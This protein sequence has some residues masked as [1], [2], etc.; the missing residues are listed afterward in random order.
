MSLPVSTLFARAIGRP[1]TSNEGQALFEA[2]SISEA[3][4]QKH[5][6]GLEELRWSINTDQGIQL[7]FENSGNMADIASHDIGKRHWLLTEALFWNDSTLTQSHGTV[8]PFG[9]RFNM[10]R[11]SV[12]KCLPVSKRFTAATADVW[13]GDSFELVVN[14]I[15]D[16]QVIRYVSYG[17]PLEIQ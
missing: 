12:Q 7:E 3:D 2:L 5:P 9:I 8:M 16:T 17:M 15:E 6:M 1:H 14:Y 4:L 11:A 10:T 13:V